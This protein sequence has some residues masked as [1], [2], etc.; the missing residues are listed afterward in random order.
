MYII[1][2]M[3][4]TFSIRDFGH[5]EFLKS[6]FGHPVKKI[7]AKSLPLAHFTCLYQKYDCNSFHML[8]TAFSMRALLT[9][10]ER[11]SLLPC[12]LVIQAI[13]AT[14]WKERYVANIVVNPHAAGG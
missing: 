2:V 7:L 4:L 8:E 1:S 11:H 14:I 9:E 5:P 13:S 12:P 3:I 6:Q 10:G